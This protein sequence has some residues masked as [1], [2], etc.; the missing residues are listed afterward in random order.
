MS[1]FSPAAKGAPKRDSSSFRHLP[2]QISNK[3]SSEAGGHHVH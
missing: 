1:D 3:T 2:S